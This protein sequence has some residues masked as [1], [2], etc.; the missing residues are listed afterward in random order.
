ME[1]LKFSPANSKTRKLAPV[2]GVKPS[3]IVGFSLPA[4]HTCPAA[5]RCLSRADRDTGKLT[6]GDSCE[7][8]CF[9]ASLECQ[10]PG[11]R[12]MVW[13]NLDMLKSA[14]VD[15]AHAMADL[16]LRSLPAKAK[17]VRLHVAGDFFNPNYV[18]A[19]VIV[20]RS[21]PQVLFYGYT[22]SIHFVLPFEKELPPNV[23]LSYSDGGKYDD[24][25]Q[26][27]GWP[28]AYVV[29]SPDDAAARGLPI[30]HKD[31]MAVVSAHDFAL[32]IHGTQP[33]GTLAAKASNA[34]K[35]RNRQEKNA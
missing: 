2:M 23:R 11:T 1:L 16:I 17:I 12:A 21:R 10:Y 24:L 15:D 22:K 19:W 18:K 27:A 32:L 7:F 5:D 6:D 28:T 4:G 31:S 9:A 3:E 35:R 13:H 34:N 26:A 30:D 20:A 8:R 29:M 25:A 33:A 14:G